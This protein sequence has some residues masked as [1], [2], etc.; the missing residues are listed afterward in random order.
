MAHPSYSEVRNQD[1][2]FG[3]A[4]HGLA[5]GTGSAPVRVT[6]PRTPYEEV[7]HG[8]WSD[9]LG[10]VLGVSDFGVHDDFFEL[11]GHSL[12]A[13]RI[14]ARIRK[15]LDVH[16]PVRDFFGCRTVAALASVVAAQSS[17]GPQVIQRR[18]AQAR[19][20]LSFDQQRLWLE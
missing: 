9:V 7:V 18:P 20:V 3:T 10:D 2:A 8:I 11:G 15:T 6:P 13:P 19:S 14:V 12:A 1:P 17:A 16:V 4:G 5:G